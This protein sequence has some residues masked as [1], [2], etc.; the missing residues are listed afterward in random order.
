MM[1][2]EEAPTSLVPLDHAQPYE[3]TVHL[4]D[5]TFVKSYKVAKANTGLPQ[6]SHGYSH[7]SYIATGA[8]KAWRAGKFLGEFHAPTGILIEAHALHFF[9]TLED[10]TTL[11]CIHSVAL[12]QEPEIEQEH[13]VTVQGVDGP[14]ARPAPPPGDRLPMDGLTFQD[15]QLDQWYED[16]PHLFRQHMIATGQGVE[17]WAKK[18]LPLARQLDAAGVL[19][20]ITARSANG[21][22]A[23]YLMSVIGP[24]LDDPLAVV[25]EQLPIF[26]SPDY[27]GLGMRL[28]K[29]SIEALR[30]RGVTEVYAKAGIRGSGP[31]LGSLFQRLGFK[32]A[33][34][35]YRLEM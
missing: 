26:A 32:D 9:K 2:D 18:N 10:N 27:P 13:Q 15:E 16:A 6:H 11:L 1:D 34:Q 20:I 5:G 12:G 22:M 28:Q 7:T 25:G 33:G 4:S 30:R 8:V 21:R 14:V 35:L 31:R 24:S 23:G 17:D 29:A 3:T 19:Q